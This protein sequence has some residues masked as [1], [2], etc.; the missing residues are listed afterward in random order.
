[1]GTPSI[2]VAHQSLLLE[3]KFAEFCHDESLEVRVGISSCFLH[4][5]PQR[6]ACDIGRVNG[7]MEQDGKARLRRC[8]YFQ[9][10]GEPEI[11]KSPKE[12]SRISTEW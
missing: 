10:F 1:M 7:G 9:G 12:S 2:M 5:N 8:H 6:L 4:E 11:K 3:I